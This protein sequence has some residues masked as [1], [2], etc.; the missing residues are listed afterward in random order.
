VPL[1]ARDLRGPG[2]TSKRSWESDTR[3]PSSARRRLSREAQDFG[4]TDLL[5]SRVG[6]AEARKVGSRRELGRVGVENSQLARAKGRRRAG[7]VRSRRELSF[8]ASVEA[9]RVVSLGFLG[10][11]EADHEVSRVE[12]GF[13]GDCMGNAGI[14]QIAEGRGRVWTEVGRRFARLTGR[15]GEREVRVRGGLRSRAP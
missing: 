13:D 1:E 7:T 11:D 5:A 8:L 9:C 10:S 14:L 4:G 3:V 2:E 6:S 15:A 12:K